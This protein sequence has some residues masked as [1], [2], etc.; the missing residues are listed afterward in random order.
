MGSS[1]LTASIE[2]AAPAEDVFAAM[3]DIRRRAEDLDAFQRVDVHDETD[4]GFM[5]TMYERYGGRD[6]VITSRFRFE[7]PRWLSY[8]HVDGPYGH[9]SGLLTIDDHGGRCT[10]TQTHR[11]EQDVSPGNPLR[12]QWLALMN[13]Q[14]TAIRDAAEAAGSAC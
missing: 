14:L 6:V 5:A 13:Q 11:T 12:E 1:E 2:I 4:D 9:N 8:E 10:L 7:R 3:V